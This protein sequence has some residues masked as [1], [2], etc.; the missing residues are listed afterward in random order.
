MKRILTIFAAFA[1]IMSLGS[2]SAILD[3][4]INNPTFQVRDLYD[5]QEFRIIRTSTC[6]YE[7]FGYDKDIVSLE[8]KGKEAWM[9]VTLPQSNS[10]RPIKTSLSAR[11]PDNLK[12]DPE[13]V[14]FEV[15]PWKLSVLEADGESWK[16]AD[17]KALEV[18][19]KYSVSMVGR[20]YGK[21][22][23]TSVAQIN[24]TTTEF[25]A[26]EWTI[27][28]TLLENIDK[29]QTYATFTV[30]KPLSGL[31]VV[32]KLPKKSCEIVLTT[33]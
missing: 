25:T 17:P 31:P 32:A 10:D 4:I 26:L 27:D 30:K 21:E 3:T 7:W 8:I 19:K 9:T 33:K 1:A 6:N 15:R 16:E 5:G 29:H 22:S 28:E 13:T 24:Y 11:N 23:W 14:E 20:D 2:C 18:G 12:V